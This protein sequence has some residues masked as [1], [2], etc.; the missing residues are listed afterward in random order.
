[1][2]SALFYL[3]HDSRSQRYEDKLPAFLKVQQNYIMKK[4]LS[5]SSSSGLP[6]LNKLR[7]TLFQPMTH[8]CVMVSP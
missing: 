7:L 6:H 3:F 8:I 5:V 2:V 1:M 4:A